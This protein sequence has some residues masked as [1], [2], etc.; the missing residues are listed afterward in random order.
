MAESGPVWVCRSC[1]G[2]LGRMRD[3]LHCGR[4]SADVP[5]GGRFWVF[6][7]DFVPAA[8]APERRRHLADIESTH[9]WFG[10]R[11]RLLA[12]ILGRVSGGGFGA[13]VDLGCGGGAFLPVLEEYAETVVGIDAYA[14]S[15]ATA[16]RVDP[17]AH[18]GQ[19]DIENPPLAEGQFEL[20]VLLDVLEHVDPDAILSRAARLTVDGGWLLI[21]VPAFPSLWSGLDE[22]AGHRCRYRFAT[23]R[24]ELERNGWR[25]VHRTHYQALAFPFVWL[26][27]RLGRS[28]VNRFERHPP[29]LIS[30]FFGFLN[31]LE[32]RLLGRFNLPWGSS[33]VVLA[34]ISH[35]CSAAAAE[36]PHPAA[37][38]HL[39]VLNVLSCTLP[40]P[41]DR[42]LHW[43][44][45][46]DA[47]A[48]KTGEK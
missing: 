34:R 18:L 22:A 14:D 45:H 29:R 19:A 13:A 2:S 17:D 39:G 12:N 7:P 11:R 27:R 16:H 15:L 40:R 3:K 10:P 35:Q 30:W 48:T 6:D 1:S 44:Q 37:L 46:L 4:C 23:L 36:A 28:R 24:A 38:S 21:S 42:K 25:V 41:S 43:A 32:V 20:V 47:L 5:D 31:A 8:F 26:A 33:L 9:F